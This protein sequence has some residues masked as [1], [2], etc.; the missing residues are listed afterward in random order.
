MLNFDGV[1][2]INL[3]YGLKFGIVSKKSLPNSLLK[4]N[5]FSRNF[6]VVG[7]TFRTIIYFESFF[8]VYGTKYRQ[9]LKINEYSIVS[10]LKS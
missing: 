1:Q 8:L 4:F 10:E 6:I 7:F 9:F 5:L 2:F 3:F